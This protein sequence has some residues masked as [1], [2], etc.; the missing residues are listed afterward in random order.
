ML[1]SY[2]K[3]VG[4]GL[5]TVPGSALAQDDN[6]FQRLDKDQDGFVSKDEVPDEQMRLFNRLLRSSDKDEDGKISQAEFKKGTERRP[7]RDQASAGN[8]SGRPPFDPQQ[9]FERIDGN[10]DGKIS[11]EEVPE[12]KREEFKRGL[13]RLGLGSA[14]AVTKEQFGRIAGL[15]TGTHD[16]EPKKGERERPRRDGRGAEEMAKKADTN[17]DGNVSKD[18]IPEERREMFAKMLE[19]LDDDGDGA[20]TIEQ[21][22]RGIQAG[23]RDGGPRPPGSAEGSPPGDGRMPAFPLMRALDV[24]GDGELSSAEVSNAAKAIA[25]LDKDGD[26]KISRREMLPPVQGGIGPGVVPGLTLGRPGEG[27]FAGE[28]LRRILEFADKD[29][30]GKISRDEAPE[31]LKR[32]FDRADSNK[33]GNLDENEIR[34]VGKNFRPQRLEAPPEL[35]EDTPERKT[36]PKKEGPDEDKE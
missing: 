6:V 4:V 23:Q 18:E 26:G 22:T 25:S 13:Q 19:R 1:R 35:K 2:I 33:D 17:G 11:S 30:D 3:W 10:K 24:D 20:L 15:L 8:E 31:I 36:E 32:G 29:K 28:G 21:F 5:L 34:E 12:N 27:V 7:E 9:L 16:G 14:A